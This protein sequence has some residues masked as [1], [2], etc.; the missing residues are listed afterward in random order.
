MLFDHEHFF[1][2]FSFTLIVAIKNPQH[3]FKSSQIDQML[4][5][6][7]LHP[8]VKTHTY[9]KWEIWSSESQL[10]T[11]VTQSLLPSSTTVQTVR[12]L[13]SL[14]VASE[15]VSLGARVAY[16]ARRWFEYSFTV[17]TYLI[18]N[19]QSLPQLWRACQK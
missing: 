15:F 16:A 19:F 6:D 3:R 14:A 9:T 1:V 7:S 11:I 17:S 18:H 5:N 2:S 13:P 8:C 10:A 4:P 12:T